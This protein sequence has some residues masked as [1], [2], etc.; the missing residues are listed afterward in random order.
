[1]GRCAGRATRRCRWP[2]CRRTRRLRGCAEAGR[3]RV[4][5]RCR[6]RAL[7]GGS[8][9]LR[10]GLHDSRARQPRHRLGLVLR[11][12]GDAL[13]QPRRRGAVGG[14]LVP[15]PRLRA[16]HAQI[17]MPLDAAACLRSIRQG[18]GLLRLPGHLQV[19]R[20]G[21]DVAGDQPGSLNEGS[22][23]HRVVGR[24]RPRQPRPVLRR[25][26]LRDRTVEAAEGPDLGRHQRRS[27]LEHP[28]RRRDL[29]Q[30]VEETS[31][32]WRR[33]ARSGRSSRH[34][35]TPARPTSRWTIT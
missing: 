20:R 2:T 28:R 19:R 9:R 12:R 21:A 5:T 7:A 3:R 13:R 24:H 15:H 1:M 10:V 14:P 16:E 17:P 33:G 8:R 34:P 29:D 25:G 27:D 6:E 18:D 30:R 31:R 22:H 23:P 11:R 32:G 35:S 4:R 26:G